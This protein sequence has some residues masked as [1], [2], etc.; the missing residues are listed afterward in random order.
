MQPERD[1]QNDS[2]RGGTRAQREG[3]FST[4]KIA[5][6][7][8]SIHNSAFRGYQNISQQRFALSGQVEAW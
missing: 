5:H 7:G 8:T 4:P 2:L 1:S 6:L 3:G